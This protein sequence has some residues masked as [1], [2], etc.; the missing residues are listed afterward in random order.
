MVK[1][2]M[3][4]HQAK[5]LCRLKP[6]VNYRIIEAVFLTTENLFQPVQILAPEP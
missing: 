6:K 4:A 2:E 5:L 1:K 3:A